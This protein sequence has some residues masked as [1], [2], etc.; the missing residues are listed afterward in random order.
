[1][2]TGLSSTNQCDNVGKDFDDLIEELLKLMEATIED[3][4][5]PPTKPASAIDGPTT[6]PSRFH[7]GSPNCPNRE[8]GHSLVRPIIH[9]RTPEQEDRSSGQ[10]DKFIDVDPVESRPPLLQQVASLLAVSV[11]E[12]ALRSLYKVLA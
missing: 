10:S 7:D 4:D 6:V 3:L 8:M 5:F 9:S 1:M 2:D 12:G 11:H